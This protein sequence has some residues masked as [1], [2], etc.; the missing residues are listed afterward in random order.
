VKLRNEVLKLLAKL[1]DLDFPV[2]FSAL[3]ILGV[4]LSIELSFGGET[5]SK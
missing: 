1:Q 5:P 4:E 3:A 2:S